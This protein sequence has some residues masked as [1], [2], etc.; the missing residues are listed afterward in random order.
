MPANRRVIG[1]VLLAALV[2]AGGTVFGAVA[3]PEAHPAAEAGRARARR[4]GARG[5]LSPRRA[6]RRTARIPGI[7]IVPLARRSERRRDADENGSPAGGD[8]TEALRLAIA[9]ASAGAATIHF[10]V[11]SQHFEEYWLFG[12]FFVGVAVLQLAWALLVIVRP[13]RRLYLAGAAGN[14][15]VVATWLV[16]R[17]T[18]LPL[19]PEGEPE[20]VGIADTVATVFEVVIAAGAVFLIR[21]TA[22][23]PLARFTVA[24]TVAALAAIA[25]T[26]LSLLSLAGL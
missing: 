19:G 20:A 7:G 10:A 4:G 13:S 18:G 9:F 16:S 12:S 21:P 8:R 3:V 23:R 1:I 11:I 24:T 25:L 17:T 2:A 6:G 22:S 5:R 15:I 26:A 14:A